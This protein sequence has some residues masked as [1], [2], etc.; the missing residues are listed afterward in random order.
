MLLDGVGLDPPRAAV[1]ALGEVHLQPVPLRRGD[2]K[3][4]GGTG[5]LR[6]CRVVVTPPPGSAKTSSVDPVAVAEVAVAA[7]AEAVGVAVGVGCA[8]TVA[9]GAASGVAAG[10]QPAS[11]RIVRSAE[12]PTP[13]VVR[14]DTG[15]LLGWNGK[16]ERRAGTKVPARRRRAE[17]ISR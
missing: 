13:A 2:E 3:G 7:G 11:R 6:V 10:V 8:S 12:A 4:E 16:R 9:E 15:D 17:S 5:F 14:V 1:G